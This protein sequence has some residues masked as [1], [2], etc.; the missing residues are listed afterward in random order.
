[1]ET[2]HDINLLTQ[3][4]KGLTTNQI[5]IHCIPNY[6]KLVDVTIVQIIG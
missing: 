3:I 4:W 2:S 6:I 1:M 5:V